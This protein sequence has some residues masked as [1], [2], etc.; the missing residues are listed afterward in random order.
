MRRI[1]FTVIV[2]ASLAA[3]AAAQ[4]APLRESAK[5]IAA[6][7]EFQPQTVGRG[8]TPAGKI[9]TALGLVGGGIAMVFLGKPDLTPSQFTPSVV[10]GRIDLSAYLGPGTYP[11]HS[12]T[13][14]HRRGDDYNTHVV[15]R[16]R[17]RTS[18]VICPADVGG[19]NEWLRETYEGGYTD[20][21]DDGIHAGMV[22]GHEHGWN[23]GQTSVLQIV[24]ENGFTVYEGPFI[25]ASYVREQLE[26]RQ[27][28]R[29]GGAALLAAGAIAALAWPDS[30]PVESLD[31]APLPGGGWLAATV[32]F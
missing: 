10:P 23:A 28:M 22:A 11:G 17:G 7:M 27:A 1:A 20:G 26:D 14:T 5:R 6:S 25:P 32:G 29:L 30:A 3:P 12:Y 24:D 4:D 13:L 19:V 9:A 18:G 2:V 15:A 8:G 21:H 31:V 16:C